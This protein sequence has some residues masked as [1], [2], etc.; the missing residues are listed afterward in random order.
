VD[1]ETP[2]IDKIITWAQSYLVKEFI[3]GD[4]LTGK[5]LGITNAPQRFGITTIADLKKLYHTK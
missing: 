3:V 5:D 4:K 1:V 2:T